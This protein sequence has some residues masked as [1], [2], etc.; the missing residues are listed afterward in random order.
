[1]IPI[2]RFAFSTNAFTRHGLEDALDRIARVGFKGVEIL[3]DKPHVWLEDFPE[4]RVDR[5]AVAL[6]RHNLFV[7]N[8]NA[9]CTSGYWKDCPPEPVFEPSVIN[10]DRSLRRWR[11]E[12]T[13]KA[14]RL[15]KTVGA[16]NVS[17]TSGKALNGVPPATARQYL[18]DAVRELLEE[19]HRL[20]VRFS[21]EYEPGLYIERTA[22]MAA[23]VAE[24]NDP[25]FGVNL[26][27][28]HVEVSGE[29]PCEAVARLRGHIFNLHV[30]D[31]LGRKHYHLVP[32]DGD[33]DLA[34]VLGAL[35]RTGYEGP[36]TWEL[37]TY[38]ED[39]DGAA[40][41]SMEYLRRLGSE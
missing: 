37:Y 29:D 17:I 34:G 20:D 18:M 41:K 10:R 33:L 25:L 40:R 14:M 22:E 39:P 5:L 2:E 11:I 23:L 30:E 27:V 36:L 13:K 35:E 28:G 9:N 38:D 26:D 1:M 21:L 24:G 6:H 15:A 19:A 32:G 8:I 3:A 16:A 31:I 12:Y 4:E 7:S